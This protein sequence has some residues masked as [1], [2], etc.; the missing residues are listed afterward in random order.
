MVVMVASTSILT[1]SILLLSSAV[2]TSPCG[3]ELS[4]GV[5][6]RYRASLS[7][8]VGIVRVFHMLVGIAVLLLLRLRLLVK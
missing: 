1:A 6:R 7:A 3:R 8:S 5:S 4:R 2:S